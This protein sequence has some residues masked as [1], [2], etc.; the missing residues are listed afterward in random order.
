M[1]QHGWYNY[2]GNHRLADKISLHT[3]YQWRRADIISTWQQSLLRMDV[4]YRI[5][6]QV[7]VTAGYGNIITWPYGEQPIPE[8]FNKHRIWEQLVLN[9]RSQRFYVNHRCRL[10]QRFIEGNSIGESDDYVFRNRI[11]YRLLMYVPLNHQELKTN[12]L[13]ISAYDEL[14]AQFGPNFKWNYLDQNRMYAGVGYQYSAHG[15]VQV[16]YLDQFVIK[17]DAQHA[18]NNHTLQLALTYNFDFRKPKE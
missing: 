9:Q 6:D 15:N 8:K 16:G 18:E 7:M 14:F 3:E 12:T 5:N 4:D 2:F 17:A 11:R 13:F 10:E 1:Q